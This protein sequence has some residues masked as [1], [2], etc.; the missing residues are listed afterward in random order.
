VDNSNVIVVLYNA[1]K[2]YSIVQQTLLERTTRE[3]QNYMLLITL[4]AFI[5]VVSHSLYLAYCS[6]ATSTN[7]I[8]GLLLW[9]YKL[10]F[11]G[12]IYCKKCDVWGVS[13]K[14]E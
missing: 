5:F 9:P 3:C 1:I 6:H 7:T 8:L 4:D 2:A 11:Y 10:V 13:K 14:I 12:S